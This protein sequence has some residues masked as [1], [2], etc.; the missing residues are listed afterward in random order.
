[1]K[2]VFRHKQLCVRGGVLFLLG[3]ILIP[4]LLQYL[5]KGQ[6]TH[7]SINLFSFPAFAVLLI[8]F[9]S[10]FNRKLLL[11]YKSFPRWTEQR[12]FLLLAVL[13]FSL[14]F[15]IRFKSHYTYENF[16]WIAIAY[17]FFYGL[18]MLLIA[19]ALFGWKF[20]R[21]TYRDLLL[22]GLLAYLFFVISMILWDVANFIGI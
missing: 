20:F 16:A 12:P 22:F 1:M 9:F 18:G 5:A 15:V 7:Y 8:V 3:F 2:K 13:S 19:V 6:F 4:A 11:S 14:Y 17:W 21:K 10:I